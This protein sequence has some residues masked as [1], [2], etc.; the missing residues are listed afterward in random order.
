LIPKKVE[1]WAVSEIR[2]AYD[3]RINDLKNELEDTVK[4]RDYYRDILFERAGLVK[5]EMPQQPVE[6]RQNISR[7]TPGQI[8]ARLESEARR[9]YWESRQKEAEERGELSVL[10]K[11]EG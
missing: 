3:G 10:S 6:I 4:E 2:S 1:T 9:K 11:T 8:S 5:R 7:M